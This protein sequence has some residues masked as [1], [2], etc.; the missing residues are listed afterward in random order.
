MIDALVVGG[1]PAG[2]SLATLLARGGRSVEVIEKTS[3]AHDGLC[4]EFLSGEAIRYLRTLDVDPDA[5]GATSIHNIRLAGSRRLGECALPFTGMSLTRR[6][7]DEA[8][9][10]AARNAGAKVTRGAR[11]EA[12]RRE[13][14]EWVARLANGEER[15]ARSAFLATGKHDLHG[16]PRPAGKQPGLIAFKMYFRLA[17]GKESAIADRVELVLFPGGYAGLLLLPNGTLNLC[18][19]AQQ[20]VFQRLGS[21]WPNL[22]DHIQSSSPC[23]ADSLQGATA[24]L[25]KPLALSSIPYGHLRSAAPEGL[26]RLG[27]QAAVIPS[28]SG[29]GISI[30]LHSAFL[31]ASYFLDGRGANDFQ[32]HLAAQ[33]RRPLQAATLISRLMIGV[34]SLARGARLWPG[35]LGSITQRTR[36]PKAALLTPVMAP[37]PGL[38][39]N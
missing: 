9:L 26:W 20:S 21:R 16:W 13:H 36:I 38:R 6:I 12:L 39:R 19:L 28:F 3:T 4:G 18:L 24:L 11:V 10:N 1:G 35:M 5:L 37:T 8:L 15:R 31:A 17:H 32:P 14:G 25:E 34:P 33:L 23:L 29:D 2:A 27:D 7:L 22:L 30:A